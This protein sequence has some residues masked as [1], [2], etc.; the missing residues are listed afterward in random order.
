MNQNELY[1]ELTKQIP[2]PTAEQLE[3]EKD[4][5]K[6]E[7]EDKGKWAE[8]SKSPRGLDILD[9]IRERRDTLIKLIEENSF[10]TGERAEVI[11]RNIQH[12]LRVLRRFKNFITTGD[13]KD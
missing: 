9:K 7:A 5:Q 3:A 13:Y 10:E 1:K 11:T 12:E 4:K 2:P 8:F 6:F